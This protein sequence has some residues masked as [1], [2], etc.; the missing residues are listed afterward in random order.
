MVSSVSTEKNVDLCIKFVSDRLREESGEPRDRGLV[1][2]IED[3]AAALLGD[4]EPGAAQQAHVVRDGGLG[5]A[6]RPL[7]VARAETLLVA[8]DQVAAGLPLRLQQL[9]DLQPRRIAECLAGGD[10]IELRRT[11]HAPSLACIITALA[12][13]AVRNSS[14][15]RSDSGARPRSS[16]AKPKRGK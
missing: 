16:T 3:P 12:G 2:R 11:R 1:A 5:E 14:D 4:H 10:E 8:R 7:D 15:C 9:E 6:D 13:H